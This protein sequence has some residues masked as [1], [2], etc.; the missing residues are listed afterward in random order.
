MASNLIL[1]TVFG[2]GDAVPRLGPVANRSVIP[3]NFFITHVQARSRSVHIA[4]EDIVALKIVTANWYID[5]TA[6]TKL[7]SGQSQTDTAAIEYPAGGANRAQ[8][9]WSGATSGTTAAGATLESDWCYVAIPSGASFAVR[10]YLTN[11]GG[12]AWTSLGG[13]KNLSLTEAFGSAAS[14][15]TDTTMTAGDVPDAGNS[16][17]FMGPVAI[18]G[19]T[20]RRT[21]IYLGDSL[22]AGLND[23]NTATGDFGIFRYLS[24][25]YG[26][27]NAARSGDRA[28]WAAARDA[29]FFDLAKYCTHAIVQ[30]S[31]NDIAN[32]QTAGQTQTSI[33]TIATALRTA[34]PYINLALTTLTPDTDSG[35]TTPNATTATARGTL[36]TWKRTIPAPFDRVIDLAAI[37]EST[38]LWVSSSYTG[39]G[40][41]TTQAGNLFAVDNGSLGQTL[42]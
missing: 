19:M 39:D 11:A 13:F 18:L 16:S 24:K 37:Y 35:N 42:P 25:T 1:G 17:N 34:N 7:N 27:I 32:S 40:R 31:I 29:T 21:V 4:R 3:N 12:V 15:L 41:H 38:G 22:A 9:R 5:G 28:V 26:Y 20:K 30:H 8:V 23:T 36:N 10:R 2:S 33:G 6:G 14:G